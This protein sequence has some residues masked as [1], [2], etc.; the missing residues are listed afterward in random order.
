MPE[1]ARALEDF[2]NKHFLKDK[3]IGF[4]GKEMVNNVVFNIRSAL[5]PGVY[6]KYPIDETR[7]NILIG[8]RMRVAAV[9]LSNLIE[10]VLK[11]ICQKEDK[12]QGR[13]T[14]CRDKADSITIKLM[15]RLPE[16]RGKLHKDI[17]AAYTGDPAALN[18]E[19]ILLSYPSVEAI[20]I[21]RIAHVLYEFGVPI[22]PRIMTEYAHQKTGID[23]HPGAKIGEYFFID[24]GTGVVI[25]ETCTIGDNV[26]L[27]QGVTLGAKSFA[28]DEQ[29]NPIK[30]IKRHP[31]IENNVIIYAGAT[32]LGGDTVIGHDSVIGG[33]VWLTHSVPPY[34]TVYNSQ[35]SP[36]IKQNKAD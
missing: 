35:P 2:N 10:K 34:S 32:I 16:I 8:N 9:E 21:Y 25:G 17:Q 26:K 29:G 13:C 36:I 3:T 27:Y 5:F 18:S 11:D 1:I 7:I 12:E 31:D 19:E 33:N 14:E 24:H 30:G 23:I 20:S 28:L 22:I 15:E 6:E 4:A